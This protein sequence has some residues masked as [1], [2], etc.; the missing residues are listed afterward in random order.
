M[1]MIF[2]LL[3][4]KITSLSYCKSILFNSHW[5]QGIVYLAGFFSSLVAPSIVIATTYGAT[6]DVGIVGLAI[7]CFHCSIKIIFTPNLLWYQH[8]WNVYDILFIVLFCS[9]NFFI[10][11]LQ[12]FF[13]FKLKVG[14]CLL[15]N[16]FVAGG[17]VSCHY[18]TLWRH[19]WRWA[20]WPDDLLFSVLYVPVLHQNDVIMGAM[21]SQI[22]SPT[23][24]F[25]TVYSDA[26]K[27]KHQISAPLAFVWGIHQ[28][29]V[30]SPHK[31][32]VTRKMFPFD[33]V[34]WRALFMFW[35]QI[36][37]TFFLKLYVIYLFV[38]LLYLHILFPHVLAEY[39][40]FITYIS[41]YLNNVHALVAHFK[42]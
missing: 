21:A 23:I 8:H 12:Y 31:W 7:F 40:W 36:A 38:R 34:S 22:T 24:V 30:S 35:T 4:L 14:N 10:V 9:V 25:S 42:W 16:F 3:C 2:V 6:D 20:C 33:D 15:D 41:R 39:K 18:D 26:D 32:P 29:P 37:S 27:R 13:L 11:L 1:Y 5:N 17:T 19:R 28:D